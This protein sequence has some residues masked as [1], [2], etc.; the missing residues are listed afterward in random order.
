MV[1]KTS[2]ETSLDSPEFV[3]PPEH[4]IPVNTYPANMMEIPPS[5]MFLIR[6]ALNVY[7]TKMG[8]DA[9]TF[10]ASQGD[11]G[12]S[13]PGVPAEILERALKIQIDHGTAYDQPWGTARFRK[14]AAESY[15]HLDSASGW[16]QDNI[17]FVQGGRDGLQKAYS[18]MIGVANQEIGGLLV[19]SRVPWISYNWGPYALGLNV[20]LAPGRPEEGWRYTPD[21]IR[22]CAELAAREGRKLAGLVITSPDNPTGR[23]IPL[24]EQIMLAQTALEVGFPFVLFDWI[25]HWVTDHG[26]SDINVIL[27][28]FSPEDRERLIFLDGL[29]KSLGASNI[30]SAHLLAGKQVVKYITSQASHSVIPSFYAQAVAIAAYEEGFAEA[31]ASIIQPTSQSRKILRAALE[32]EGINHIMGDGYYAFIDCTPYIEAGGLKDSEA[33]LTYLGE[34]YGIAI[35]AG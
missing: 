32:R 25:Y 24:G 12:A 20:L 27:Q 21:G 30:R 4:R 5:R 14:A 13:L 31:A 33:L 34:N 10:D 35:V 11:G 15:W 3:V 29:T 18:A 23:T 6:D 2:I 22:A 7:R 8:A 17:V 16:G 26:P 9:V 28:A 1:T 19:V